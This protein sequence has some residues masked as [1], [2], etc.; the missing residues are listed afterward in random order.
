MHAFT[1]VLLISSL[2]CASSTKAKD[3]STNM[4]AQAIQP[5]REVEAVS[6]DQAE[7]DD[8]NPMVHTKPVDYASWAPKRKQELLAQGEEAILMSQL[9]SLVPRKENESGAE[10]AKRYSDKMNELIR[11]GVSILNDH[12]THETAPDIFSVDGHEF[13]VGP[14]SGITK[15]EYREFSNFIGGEEAVTYAD[16]PER[17]LKYESKERLIDEQK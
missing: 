14:H 8:D 15:K 11:E 5:A 13:D 16:V 2:T 9:P 6:M 3:T 1:V 17:F 12:T 7:N 4:S 10:Y